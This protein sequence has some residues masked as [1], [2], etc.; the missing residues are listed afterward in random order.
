LS[1]VARAARELARAIRQE[2]RAAQRRSNMFDSDL[3]RRIDAAMLDSLAAGP[4]SVLSAIDDWQRVASGS[5]SYGVGRQGGGGGPAE[6]R[7]ALTWRALL[8]EA[9]AA[10]AAAQS[11]GTDLDQVRP[12]GGS[13][14]GTFEENDLAEEVEALE[15]AAARRAAARAAKDAHRDALL[16]KAVAIEA[17]KQ[18]GWGGGVGLP[19]QQHG[20]DDEDENVEDLG[21]GGMGLEEFEG[22]VR[23]Q[24]EREAAAALSR[25]EA[26]LSKMDV[27]GEARALQVRALGFRV[28]WGSGGAAVAL[29]VGGAVI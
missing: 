12:G 9:R 5:K 28:S 25:L 16:Q 8:Q 6:E 4:G 2:R 21:L 26:A 22:G 3:S 7:W 13:G 17:A 23:R 20:E 10:L 14:A 19:P 11:A 24:R 15:R 1:E 27:A 18:Q 29:R